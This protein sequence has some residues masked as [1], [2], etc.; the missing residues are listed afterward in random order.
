M[1]ATEI[2]EA[3]V[4]ALYAGDDDEARRFYPYHHPENY[5][6]E[7]ALT[8]ERLAARP[9]TLAE[10]GDSNPVSQYVWAE[11]TTTVSYSGA[12]GQGRLPDWR[13]AAERR[14]QDQRDRAVDRMGQVSV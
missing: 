14:P 5:T 7:R 4:R 9:L 13:A 3:F 1:S 8:L 6:D 11:V 2:A 10:A 12:D